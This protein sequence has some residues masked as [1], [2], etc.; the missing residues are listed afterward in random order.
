MAKNPNRKPAPAKRSE[1]MNG[2]M[3]FFLIGCVAEFYLFV[4]RRYFVNG[5]IEQVLAWNDY[6]K[7]IAWFGVGLL[8]VGLAVGYVMKQQKKK[9]PAFGWA[10][11]GIGA[12]L[13][14]SG[15]FMRYYAESGATLLSVVVPVAMVLALL[16]GF[17]DR[18]CS[19]SLTI[20]SVS[21][22]A[23]WVYYRKMPDLSW[24]TGL[25]ISAV[26]Y[27]ALLGCAAWLAKGGKLTPILPANADPMPVYIA[28]GLSAVGIVCALIST[29]VV[30]YAMWALAV[31]VFALAVY[32]TVKML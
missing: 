5:T 28:C 26:V 6:L 27:L 15:F 16:W 14:F 9:N 13:A 32:Y 11:A 21:L 29:T 18:E 10:V 4:V 25:M 24:K 19:V 2:A 23:L 17:Y 7:Y 31:V 22:V 20:L 30:Y 1:A 8:I 3:I 12:F